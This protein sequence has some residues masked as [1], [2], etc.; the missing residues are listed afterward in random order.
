MVHD[1]HVSGMGGNCAVTCIVGMPDAGCR[2]RF[3]PCLSTVTTSCS[4]L[5]AVSMF[6]LVSD[7]GMIFS[8]I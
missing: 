8:Y 4:V 3:W 1:E 6:L 2:S 5:C 7:C